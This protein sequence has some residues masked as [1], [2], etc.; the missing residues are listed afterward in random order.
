MLPHFL[1]NS[2]LQSAPLCSAQPIR[3][4]RDF[5]DQKGIIGLVDRVSP[6]GGKIFSKLDR[7]HSTHRR[8]IPTGTQAGSLVLGRWLAITRMMLPQSETHSVRLRTILNA[9]TRSPTGKSLVIVRASGT[10]A[11]V[12]KFSIDQRSCLSIEPPNSIHQ[13]PT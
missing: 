1:P 3:F 2:T 7:S 11:L 6:S 4:D 9:P 13:S 8:M 10:I 12:A 5:L